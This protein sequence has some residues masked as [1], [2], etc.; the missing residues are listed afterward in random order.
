M[1]RGKLHSLNDIDNSLNNY[2][3]DDSK[4]F[5]NFFL[6]RYYF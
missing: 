6:N 4:N 1:S 2:T 3:Q 5:S